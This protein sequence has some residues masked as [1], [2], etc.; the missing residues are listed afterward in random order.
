M[1]GARSNKRGVELG[2][3]CSFL[4]GTTYLYLYKLG[5]KFFQR[6]SRFQNRTVETEKEFKELEACAGERGGLSVL[7]PPSLFKTI[8][9]PVLTAER[10]RAAPLM[11]RYQKNCANHLP[12]CLAHSM[13]LSVS[14]QSQGDLLYSGVTTQITFHLSK[15]CLERIVPSFP[16]GG[17]SNIPQGIIIPELPSSSSSSRTFKGKGKA[18]AID[19]SSASIL[20]GNGTKNGDEEGRTTGMV[21]LSGGDRGDGRD[22]IARTQAGERLLISIRDTWKDHC[23]CLS[24]LRDVLKYVV[25]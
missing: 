7:M 25:S 13:T 9:L 18:R 19:H 5:C 11:K 17:S 2:P 6:Y 21:N 12:S 8:F 24:K 4:S 16:S 14:Q 23:L 10:K 20:N 3:R 1:N 22:E 15:L